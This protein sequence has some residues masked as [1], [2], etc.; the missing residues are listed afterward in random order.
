MRLCHVNS[1]FTKPLTVQTHSCVS[2]TELSEI[3]LRQP[4]ETSRTVPWNAPVR[5]VYWSLCLYEEECVHERMKRAV[6]CCPVMTYVAS[7][8]LVIA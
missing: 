4:H 3:S 7:Y 1:A 6:L 2:E 8:E 5:S